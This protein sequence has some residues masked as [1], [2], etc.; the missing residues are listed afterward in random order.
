MSGGGGCLVMVGGLMGG[1][2]LEDE[3]VKSGGNKKH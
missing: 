1:K 3:R 2:G